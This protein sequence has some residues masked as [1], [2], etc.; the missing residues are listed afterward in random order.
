MAKAS[1]KFRELPGKTVEVRQPPK[2]ILCALC[3]HTEDQHRH[4]GTCEHAR[5]DKQTKSYYDHCRCR[6]FTAP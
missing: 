5:F 3:G 4:G 2:L 1:R 6:A